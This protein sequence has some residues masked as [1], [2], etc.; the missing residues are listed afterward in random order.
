MYPILNEALRILQKYSLCCS[1]LGRAF[2]MLGRGLTNEERGRAIKLV[3]T[4]QLHRKLLEGN[5]ETLELIKCIARSS[6]EP[7]LLLLEK[8]GVSVET[9]KCFICSNVFEKLEDFVSRVLKAVK[10]IEFNTLLV[11][12]KIPTDITIKEE[13]IREEFSLKFSENIKREINRRVGKAL[14]SSLNKAYD[15][16]APDLTI[17]L[18]LGEN[19]IELIIKPLL[20]YGR[21]RKL[22][23]GIPQSAGRGNVTSETKSRESIEEYIC[24]P[25]LNVT[26]GKRAILHASGREDV[27]VRVLGR[28]RPFV[29]E[30]KDPLV[31]SIDLS[32]VKKKVSEYSEGKVD[33]EGLRIVDQRKI[34]SRIKALSQHLNKTYRAVV[35]FE[36]IVDEK[37]LEVL[38]KKFENV[39]VRQR[40]PTRVLYR[41]KD[42][43]R[44]KMVYSLR[45][46]SLNE[47]TIELII[48]CQ[49]GL[50]VKELITGDSGRTS[51]SIAEIL[52]SQPK[53]IELDIIDIEEPFLIT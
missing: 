1:C 41:R 35:E 32:L 48:K 2:A 20:I 51:P 17:L 4:M 30:V 11:G 14:C 7:A 25:I 46:R 40:T 16:K 5:V 43:V 8:Y 23:R 31:R 33:V 53:K 49:G 47:N 44:N 3:L 38:E 45:A 15:P 52:G 21:Y 37:M 18:D 10:D 42:K 39:L 6:F 26:H 27:D 22:V 19:T 9:S 34:I 12:C 50:Y 13:K 28:G 24:R 29:V 36:E